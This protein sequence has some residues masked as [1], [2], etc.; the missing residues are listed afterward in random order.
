MTVVKSCT[1]QN[2]TFMIAPEGQLFGE[3]GL[4]DELNEDSD[5]GLT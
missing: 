3:V 5:A 1:I 4:N 2:G